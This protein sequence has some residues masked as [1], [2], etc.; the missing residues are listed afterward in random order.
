[1]SALDPMQNLVAVD[2]SNQTYQKELPKVL[3]WRADAERAQGHFD[4]AIAARSRQIALL[5]QAIALGARDVDFREQLII[6]HQA[7]GLLFTSRGQTERGIQELRSAVSEADNL[8]P[9]EPANAQWKRYAAR[10]RLYLANALLP[11]GGRDEASQQTESAC[12]IL[13]SLP[14]DASAN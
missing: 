2:P 5:D 3:A 6:A 4:S 11:A 8:I 7:L 13:A 10:A 12:N 1:E 9:V 14:I